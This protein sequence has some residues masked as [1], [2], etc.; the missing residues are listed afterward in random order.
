MG[1][2]HARPGRYRVVPKRPFSIHNDPSLIPNDFPLA[3]PGRRATPIHGGTDV[4]PNRPSPCTPRITKRT[5]SHFRTLP[6]N[7]PQ[8]IDSPRPQNLE[9]DSTR[10]PPEEPFRL[11]FLGVSASAL[12]SFS[13]R[14]LRAL[15]GSAV[16][17]PSRSLPGSTGAC[18]RFPCPNGDAVLA[19]VRRLLYPGITPAAGNLFR[20]REYS[21]T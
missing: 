4:E 10:T 15:R 16:R 13:P 18:A 17:D 20:R 1:A 21:I 8:V 11:V 19:P 6:G 5:Q 9:E 2:I 7:K 3:P 14:F 12:G